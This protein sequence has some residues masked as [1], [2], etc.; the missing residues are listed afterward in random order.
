MEIHFESAALNNSRHGL[1][2]RRGL[3]RFYRIGSFSCSQGHF[4]SILVSITSTSISTKAPPTKRLRATI[5]NL[6]FTSTLHLLGWW[7][8]RHVRLRGVC[9]KACG[10]KSRPEHYLIYIV[11]SFRSLA[12]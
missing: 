10:F 4:R 11:E 6:P 2:W 12:G 5:N 8:G 3:G 1:K 9:R 7:N